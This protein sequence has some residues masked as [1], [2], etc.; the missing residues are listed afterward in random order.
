MRRLDARRLSSGRIGSSPSDKWAPAHQPTVQN[1]G[2]PSQH[3]ETPE[4]AAWHSRPATEPG[5]VVLIEKRS[6][7]MAL[8][9]VLTQLSHFS[10]IVHRTSEGY[11]FG[12]HAY[13][14]PPFTAHD[15]SAAFSNVVRYVSDAKHLAIPGLRAAAWVVVWSVADWVCA[16]W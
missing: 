1:S 4:Q 12:F 11:E 2:L 9:R 8:E 3:V 15:P 7:G 10:P 5:D 16:R 14:L 6:R 13:H